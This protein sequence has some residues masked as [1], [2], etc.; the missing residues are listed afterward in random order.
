MS[1]M[2][3]LRLSSSSKVDEDTSSVP[4]ASPAVF[5]DVLGLEVGAKGDWDL[6]NISLSVV[7]DIR[8]SL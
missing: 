5:L 8:S 3:L 7:M 4:A 1:S 2:T 6:S